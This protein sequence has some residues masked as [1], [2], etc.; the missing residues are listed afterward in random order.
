[1]EWGS[2]EVLFT[3]PVRAKMQCSAS[4]FLKGINNSLRI[5]VR[6]LKR[7]KHPPLS[8]ALFCRNLADGNSGSRL[9]HFS[10]RMVVC[11]FNCHSSH[12]PDV[13]IGNHNRRLHR[14][15]AIGNHTWV[16][17]P[18]SLRRKRTNESFNWWSLTWMFYFARTVGQWCLL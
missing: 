3:P 2:C 5:L 18:L 14:R 4:S 6:V 8:N 16:I 1:M 7:N 11:L 17:K 13:S 15:V 9:P 12:S 10:L